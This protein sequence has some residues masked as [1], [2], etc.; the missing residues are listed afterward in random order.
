MKLVTASK[1]L[2]SAIVFLI[3]V[4]IAIGIWGWNELDKPYQINQD[5]QKRK[6][7]FD[8]DVRILLERYL[9]S[10][11]ADLLQQA[12][13]KL[14]QLIESDIEWLEEEDNENIKHAVKAIQENVQLIR[15]AGKLAADPQGLLIN[16]ERERS[17]DINLLLS[18]VNKTKG[19]RL[20]LQVAFLSE[21]TRLS[22]A[23]NQIGRLR[24]QYFGATDVN[25]QAAL[26][27]K[28]EEV[29]MRAQALLS[30]PSLGIYSEVDEDALVAEEPEE[31]GQRSIQS[32]ISLT[33]RYDKELENTINLDQRMQESR[34]VLIDSLT[35]LSTLLTNLS[36]Q[37]ELIK[38]NISTKVALMLLVSIGLVVIAVA[39]LFF[40]QNRMIGFL[41]QLESFFRKLLNADYKQQLNSNFNF[42]EV[43]SVENS[44]RQ[45]QTYLASLVDKLSSESERVVSACNEMQSVSAT[46][47]DL[48]RKQDEST[49]HV[50]AAVTEL[51]YSFKEV[52]NNAAN[53]SESANVADDAT[54]AAKQQLSLAATATQKMVTDLLT[55]EEV[56]VRLE[57][58][59]ESIGVVL[60]VIRGVAEQTNLLALNAAI[61][62]ARAGDHG[63]GFAVVA[64]EV[65]Q[66][67]SRTT[68]STEEIRNII[69]DVIAIS[70][71]A[72][73]TLKQQSQEASYCAQQA[74][75]AETAI[76]PVV[77]AVENIKALNTAI[78]VA[79]QEQ[80]LTVDEI[81]RNTEE[82][83]VNSEFVNSNISD[84]K[85]AGDSLLDV[86]ETLNGL[87]RQLKS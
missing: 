24:Q 14:A 36:G 71:E 12:E 8:V 64:D 47:V 38:S 54:L 23:L 17:G 29:L 4:S 57:K 7:L 16:N 45:L 52:A 58:G 84:I 1:L 60:E 63:R 62:A 13:S 28:N 83:K 9:A 56:M 70:A 78:A 32:I 66:L 21:L 6:A 19:E 76:T 61:E 3:S 22:E 18:Y 11:N 67:A 73:Q 85:R 69:Q 31:I 82:I 72:T 10:G 50:A 59:G 5:F 30:L 75:D 26:V 42:K 37:I 49:A 53:A 86:S 81:A 79:T 87:I 43:L 35:A 40:L 65:R 44:G 15:A 74:T 68:Q 80:T 55:V 51:S 41:I 25:V 20:A 27:S 2:L 33:K 34:V 48:T 77:L 39:A 46:A